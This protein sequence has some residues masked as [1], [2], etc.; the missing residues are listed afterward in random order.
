MANQSGSSEGGGSAAEVRRLKAELER[1]RAYKVMA[2]QNLQEMGFNLQAALDQGW[3]SKR[4]EVRR[5]RLERKKAA[6]AAKWAKTN[7][8]E[9]W[10]RKER[11]KLGLPVRDPTPT[12]SEAAYLERVADAAREQTEERLRNRIRRLS[13]QLLIAAAIGKQWQEVTMADHSGHFVPGGFDPSVPLRHRPFDAR[14][15]TSLSTTEAM[16]RSFR[17]WANKEKRNRFRSRSHTPETVVVSSR[18][19]G[20]EDSPSG[21]G[22]DSS[23]T[24]DD[25]PPPGGPGIAGPK[26]LRAVI[27]DPPSDEDDIIDAGEELGGLADLDFDD[28]SDEVMATAFA[29][30]ATAEHTKGEGDWADTLADNVLNIL[31]GEKP[32]T[33]PSSLSSDSDSDSDAG[34]PPAPLHWNLDTDTESSDTDSQITLQEEIKQALKSFQFSPDLRKHGNEK[35]Q[36]RHN[37]KRGRRGRASGKNKASKT[38]TEILQGVN[39]AIK[40]HSKQK[41][42]HQQVTPKGSPKKLTEKTPAPDPEPKPK[43]TTK[44]TQIESKLPQE[45]EAATE[46]AKQ[47][48][49]QLKQK[50]KQKLKLKQKQQKEKQQKE[51][52][53]KEKQQ[54]EKQPPPPNEDPTVPPN[55]LDSDGDKG[56]SHRAPHKPAAPRQSVYDPTWWRVNHTDPYDGPWAGAV[57]PPKQRTTQ[58]ETGFVTWEEQETRFPRLDD[59]LQLFYVPSAVIFKH[60]TVYSHVWDPLDRTVTEP[61]TTRNPLVLGPVT[62]HSL[63]RWNTSLYGVEYSRDPVRQPDNPPVEDKKRSLPSATLSKPKEAAT[64]KTTTMGVTAWNNNNNNNNQGGGGIGKGKKKKKKTVA[65]ATGVKAK[66]AVPT[67]ETPIASVHYPLKSPATSISKPYPDGHAAGQ[68]QTPYVSWWAAPSSSGKPGPPTPYPRHQ[69]ETPTVALYEHSGVASSSASEESSDEEQEKKLATFLQ[70]IHAG[71]ASGSGSG[72]STPNTNGKRPASASSSL[73]AKKRLTSFGSDFATPVAAAAVAVGFTG[74]G[75]EKG[76]GVDASVSAELQAFGAAAKEYWDKQQPDYGLRRPVPYVKSSNLGY[77][78]GAK[79]SVRFDVNEGPSRGMRYGA[80]RAL[81]RYGLTSS[82]RGQLGP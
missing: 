75:K 21:S 5:R 23:F 27:Y 58:I 4:A 76:A 11:K 19:T 3:V 81:G 72:S 13:H 17:N 24:D 26:A 67:D 9:A 80:R 40:H 2:E 61:K 55:K 42:P 43:Y 74:T 69:P 82:R 73:S 57:L 18:T 78:G 1:L 33:P 79:K 15:E 53:Q 54:K 64:K 52:Q 70:E 28:V 32:N 30:L 49:R 62:V 68:Q 10:I 16:A 50:L 60:L 39:K 29:M 25:A 51:K 31:L 14:S 46:L 63:A 65:F 35:R 37:N 34:P 59:R 66:M 20:P 22:S 7:E 77:G 41:Q 6:E 47:Q 38:Q 12:P 36:K 45:V 71:A 48:K 44:T 8:D 56:P